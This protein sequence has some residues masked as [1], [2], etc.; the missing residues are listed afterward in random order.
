MGLLIEKKRNILFV[1]DEQNILNGI[2]RMLR[3]M[4]KE[5]N[6]QFANSPEEALEKLAQTEFDIIVSDMRMPGMNGVELLN[7]VKNLYPTMIRFILS[8]YAE[9]ELILS[10]SGVTHQFLAK[11]CEPEIIKNTIKKAFHL[12]DLLNS[13]SL[14]NVVKQA[15]AL[16]TLPDLYQKLTA[17]LKRPDVNAEIIA[18]IV[19][20]D[21]TITAKILQLVN[22][23]FFGIPQEIHT[24]NQAV[25]LLGIETI[26]SLVFTSGT[27]KQFENEK[28]EKYGVRSLYNHS[29]TTAVIAK[30]IM[31]HFSKNKKLGEDAM[32][33]GMVHD[34]GKLILIN[35]YTDKWGDVLKMQE[36]AQVPLPTIEKEILGVT[37]CEIGAYMLGAW[38][39][40]DNIVEAVL[41]HHTPLDVHPTTVTPLIALHIAN[42]LEHVS[43]NTP[44]MGLADGILEKTGIQIS[45]DELKEIV[46]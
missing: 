15:E 2:R 32:F 36:E 5:W 12:R 40:S 31:L 16:P 44:G 8:G 25:S 6:M 10:A 30:K 26:N 37:H 46:L 42:T 13:E 18:E 4:R 14:T 7:E 29:I 20:Q 33:A 35:N 9:R 38:G 23:A 39:L 24:I 1:D 41:F 27:F 34:F 22:S 3:V 19:A 43:S 11:P 45:L 17:A 21:V 28:V